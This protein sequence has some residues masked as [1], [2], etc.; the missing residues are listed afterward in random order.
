L[1]RQQDTA[2]NEHEVIPMYTT[3][4]EPVELAEKIDDPNWLLLDCRFDLARP[5]WGAGAFAEGHVPNALYAH[6]DRDLSSPV[7]PTSGRHPLPSHEAFLATLGRWGVDEK[8]QVVAYDQGNGAYASRLWWLVRWAGHTRVAVLNGGFA[9]WQQ[10]A[11]PVSQQTGVRL[12]RRFTPTHAPAEF[13]STSRIADIL[14]AGQLASGE[15]ALVDA[16][17]AD[18]FAGRNETLDPVAGHIPGARNYPFMRNLDPRGRFLP[19]PTLR[20]QWLETLGGQAPSNA[21]AMCGSGVTACHNLLA[22]EVAG[23]PGARLYA[24]SWSE[25]IRDAARPVE[26]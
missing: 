17:A 12:P 19:A 20:S 9:A 25:W 4:I 14:A 11:L 10:A 13:V 21:I 8:V 26:R 23:L 15:R 16:R 2:E 24:G 6:L 7:T 3:L 1:Y 22:L 5:E 18:R